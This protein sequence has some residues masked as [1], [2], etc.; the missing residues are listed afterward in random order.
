[1]AL[2]TCADYP[3]G[4]EDAPPVVAALAARGVEARAEVWSDRSVE[5]DRY[6]LVVVRSTWDYQERLDE[7]LA[8]TARPRRILNPRPVLAW[9]TDKE[10]YLPR[11]AAAGVPVVPSAFVPPTLPFRPPAGDYV[12][13]PAVGAG[14]RDSAFFGAADAD[15]AAAL[16]ARIH[17][18]GRTALVQPFLGEVSETGLVFIGGAFSHAVARR[19]PLPRRRQEDVLF[20]EEHVAPTTPSAHALE[21]AAAAL[22]AAPGP[23][24]YA[25]VDVV[26]EQLLELEL[27]EP[28]L[29]LGLAPASAERLAAAVDSA[30]SEREETRRA[31]R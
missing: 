20:L 14:G 31:G 4:D 25:R 29:Y 27:A 3:D 28:S 11:L 17:A 9:T 13:K 19:V 21:L 30:V 22:A 1:V 10:R 15:E 26:G 24:L 2:A 12:V 16:V 23:L 18:S 6:D 5:W 8:W 7:F